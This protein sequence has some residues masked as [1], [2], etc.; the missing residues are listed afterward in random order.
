[1]TT[2]LKVGKTRKV[3]TRSKRSVTLVKRPKNA[4]KVSV[5]PTP[6]PLTPP[7]QIHDPLQIV[8]KKGEDTNVTSAKI[9]VG[10]LLSSANAIRWFGKGTLGNDISINSYMTALTDS[11]KEINAND[12]TQVEAMLMGQA[13]A[14]NVMFGELTCWAATNLNGSEYRMAME[15]Y[16]KLAMKAQNQCRMTLETLSNIK[17]PPVV[18][19]RQANI[20]NGPQQVNNGAMPRAHAEENQIQPNK[21]LEQSN[22]RRMDTGTKGQTSGGN[23]PMETL[24]KVN[25]P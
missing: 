7:K 9:L 24:A 12:L 23:S 13:T 6:V 18:Y 20:A 10:P 17:N 11:T 19:A 4:T 15:T 2:A 3:V 16:F 1:M 25:G 5:I 8:A 21:L 22:E 14:L